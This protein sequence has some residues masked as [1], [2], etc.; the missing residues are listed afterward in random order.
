VRH[1]YV[2]SFGDDVFSEAVRQAI[3]GKLRT[4]GRFVVTE[5]SD[6][7]DTAV[8]G[9]AKHPA[10][11]NEGAGQTTVELVNVSGEVIWPTREYDGTPE[12]VAGQFTKELLEAIQRQKSKVKRQK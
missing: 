6:D 5:I 4:A 12:Q 3:I 1:I 10:R 7:A 11:G 2:E 8:T 9:S